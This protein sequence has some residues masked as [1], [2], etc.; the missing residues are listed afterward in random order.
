MQRVEIDLRLPKIMGVWGATGGV[1]IRISLGDRW[2]ECAPDL[3]GVERAGQRAADAGFTIDAMARAESRRA[4]FNN[5]MAAMFDQ[6][7]IVLAATNPST[8]FGAEGHLPGTFEGRESNPGNNGALTAPSNIYGNPAI[9]LPAGLAS[10]GLPVS[11]QVLA[12]H[13]REDLLLDLALQWERGHPV[14]LAP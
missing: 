12:P 11:L 9:A 14:E 1:G 2:P 10:D 8:A 6:A 5:A 7:D 4:E 3:G 13:F